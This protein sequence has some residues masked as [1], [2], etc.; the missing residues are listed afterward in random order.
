[1]A[2]FEQQVWNK[3]LGKD[4]LLGDLS[5]IDRSPI[6]LI[7]TGNLRRFRPVWQHQDKC[8]DCKLCVKTCPRQAIARQEK[9]PKKFA[10]VVD[11]D[12]CIG[13]GFCE[14]ICPCQVWELL[15]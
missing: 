14:S 5:N 7:T 1:M 9:N 10:Y 13:C 15:K 3:E 6:P 2:E 11:D 4:G 8:I 12:K